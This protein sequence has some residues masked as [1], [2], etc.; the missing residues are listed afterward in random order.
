MHKKNC[1]SSLLFW[2]FCLKIEMHK[3]N[4]CKKENWLL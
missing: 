2:G 1:I 3:K 4:V